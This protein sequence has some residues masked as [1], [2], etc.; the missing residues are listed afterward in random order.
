MLWCIGAR[1]APCRAHR[2]S[3][4]TAR[5]KTTRARPVLLIIAAGA[6]L[7][8]AACQKP[9]LA[10]DEERSPFDRYD[11]VRNQHAD[12]QVMDPFGRKRPNLRERLGP[13]E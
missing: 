12:Q 10:E 1:R 4:Y 13:K 5:V 3:G 9:L 11:A 6:A 8:L 7:A 2:L